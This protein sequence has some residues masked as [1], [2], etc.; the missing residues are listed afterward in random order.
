M[1][2]AASEKSV[3]AAIAALAR[4]KNQINIQDKYDDRCESKGNELGIR[5]NGT[6]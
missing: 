3:F 6:S 2:V 1:K 4:P 5:V